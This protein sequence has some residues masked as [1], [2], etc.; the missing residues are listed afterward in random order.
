MLALLQLLLPE[1][2]CHQ[3]V[4]VL[5]HSMPKVLASHTNA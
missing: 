2:A 4:T 1:I 5:I 3:G